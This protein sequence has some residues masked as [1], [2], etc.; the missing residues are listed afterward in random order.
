MARMAGPGESPY[1]QYDRDIARQA[2]LVD[3]RGAPK[4][5]DKPWLLFVSFVC[6]HYPLTAPPE[7]YFRYFDDPRLV[8]AVLSTATNVPIIPSSGTTPSP[9]IS[10]TT[11]RTDR[12]AARRRG[13]FRPV[14]L[15]GPAGRTRSRCVVGARLAAETACRLHVSDHGDAVGKRGL[16]ASPPSM[17][18]RAGVPLIV[19]G[20]GL[21]IAQV[22]RH[23]GKTCRSFI[24]SSSNASAAR[25]R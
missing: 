9:S 13:L 19:A 7:F 4:H 16:W 18:R 10:T 1:T 25:T 14:W 5:A 2:E 23:A 24:R 20:E 3:R 12:R 21:P 15:H 11:S 6:P 17:K 8:P 22:R